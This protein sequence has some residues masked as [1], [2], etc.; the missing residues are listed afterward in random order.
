V[1]EDVLKVELHSKSTKA[2][3]DWWCTEFTNQ[4]LA[5]QINF[6]DPMEIS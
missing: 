1:N 5:L 6:T 3:V 4:T 2:D